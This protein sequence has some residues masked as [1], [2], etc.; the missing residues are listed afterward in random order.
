VKEELLA[1]P[2]SEVVALLAIGFAHTRTRRMARRLAL[3][4]IVTKKKLAALDRQKSL[5]APDVEKFRG[6]KKKPLQ[7]RK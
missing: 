1:L 5:I 3:E 4:D 7:P 6:T 2:R